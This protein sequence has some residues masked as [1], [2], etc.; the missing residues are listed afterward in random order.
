[1]QRYQEIWNGTRN[2]D[3][4][5]SLVTRTFVGHIGSRDR[6]LS[7]L[8]SDIRAYRERAGDVRFE[9]MHRFGEGDHVA[10]RAMAHVTDPASG[11]TVS[12]CGL[13]ISRW[14]GGLL[15]EEWAVWEPLPTAT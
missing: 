4:L 6:D 1:M 2:V 7:E 13:N 10:T 11:S 14:E 15:A 12:I 8:K 9:V 5:D 3:E